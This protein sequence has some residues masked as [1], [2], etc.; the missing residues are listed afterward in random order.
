MNNQ[1]KNNEI[2]YNLT[3]FSNGELTYVTP[4]QWRKGTRARKGK[5]STYVWN[6]FRVTI[7]LHIFLTQVVM[8]RA[9]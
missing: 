7:A 6:D 1:N 5:V 9:Q 4:Q 2:I 3:M 8:Q